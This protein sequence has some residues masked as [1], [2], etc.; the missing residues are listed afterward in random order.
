M[1]GESISGQAQLI[2]AAEATTG[3]YHWFDEVLDR[4]NTVTL[5]DL[6][7]VRALYLHRRHRTVGWYE[8][9]DGG[10]E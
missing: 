1:A 8:P 2:G 10:A 4:L 3:D 6:E 9:E 5:D 7:R